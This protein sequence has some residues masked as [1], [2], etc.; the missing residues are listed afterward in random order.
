MGPYLD[1]NTAL[2]PEQLALKDGVHQ[3]AQAV[4]RP[5]AIALDKLATPA[6]VIASGSPLWTALKAS[7]AQ[8]F[9]TAL[10]PKQCGGLGL[11][12]LELHLA[13]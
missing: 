1:M 12:G 7:Y 11:T 2:S 3:F 4:L 9:H 10:I 13:L 8:G 5:A 6:E